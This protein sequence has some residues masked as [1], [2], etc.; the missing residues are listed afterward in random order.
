[1]TP[2]SQVHS[3]YQWILD[4]EGEDHQS[5]WSLPSRWVLYIFI[6]KWTQLFWQKMSPHFH[7]NSI[8]TQE[9]WNWQ[10]KLRSSNQGETIFC[11]ITIISIIIIIALELKPMIFPWNFKISR[12]EWGSNPVTHSHLD[13]RCVCDALPIIIELP[14]PWEQCDGEEVL[15]HHLLSQHYCVIY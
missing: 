14:N 10:L 11:R 2:D 5:M 3:K 13:L 6:V 15:R 7:P 12:L 8:S 1:M 9:L 4:Q